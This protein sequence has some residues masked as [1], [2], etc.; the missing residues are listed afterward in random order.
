[1]AVAEALAASNIRDALMDA[2]DHWAKRCEDR[3]RRARLLALAAEVEKRTPDSETTR[4]RLRARSSEG[5]RDPAALRRLERE[6]RFAAQ[7]VPLLLS[8]AQAIRD[9][10]RD[11]IPYMKKT[12]AAHSGDFWVNLSLGYMFVHMRENQEA[13]RYLQA[14]VTLRSNS[15]YPRVHL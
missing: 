2:L 1:A 10:Q 12:L 7:R 11:P 3:P 4:W 6:T 13:I 8:V 14:A 5:L 9:S 15:A